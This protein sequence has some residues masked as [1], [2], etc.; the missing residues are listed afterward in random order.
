MSKSSESTASKL[1]E[2]TLT[3]TKESWLKRPSACWVIV[4]LILL[5]VPIVATVALAIYSR[6]AEEWGNPNDVAITNVTGRSVTVSWRTDSKTKGLVI[7]GE[8]KSFL[9]GVFAS[10]SKNVA[11][12]DRDVVNARLA[13][14]ERQMSE[15]E[16]SGNS[17]VDYG[18][19]EENVV[20]DE[21]GEY[22]VHHVTIGDLDPEKKYFFMIGNGLRFLAP[23]VDKEKGG[24]DDNSFMTYAELEDVPMPSPAYGK[25]VRKVSS[26]IIVED[27]EKEG[28]AEFQEIE[29]SLPVSDGVMYMRMESPDGTSSGL[30]SC[31]LAENGSWYIDLS[32]IRMKDGKV[33]LEEVDEEIYYLMEE[34]LQVKTGEWDDITKVITT[35]NDAP[36]DDIVVSVSNEAAN[37]EYTDR[38]LSQNSGVSFVSKVYAISCANYADGSGCRDEGGGCNCDNGWVGHVTCEAARYDCSGEAPAGISGYNDDVNKQWIAF[39]T[40]RGANACWN[41][42]N[43]GCDDGGGCRNICGSP[44][45]WEYCEE[46][47]SEEPPGGGGVPA[48]CVPGSNERGSWGE[49]GV[50]DG[51]VRPCKYHEGY[52]TKDGYTC[53]ADGSW[54]NPGDSCGG[55][56]PPVVPDVCTSGPDCPI[57]NYCRTEATY[58]GIIND[59][60]SYDA[61]LCCRDRGTKNEVACCCDDPSSNCW[62]TGGGTPPGGKYGDCRDSFR[63]WAACD[64][65]GTIFNGFVCYGR[66]WT[67]H[68]WSQRIDDGSTVCTAPADRS[69]VCTIGT[70][71]EISAGETCATIPGAVALPRVSSG[72][73]CCSTRCWCSYTPS[74]DAYQH[75]IVY[76]D[77]CRHFSASWCLMGDPADPDFQGRICYQ[78][79]TTCDCGWLG[80]TCTGPKATQVCSVMDFE[81]MECMYDIGSES[82]GL[83]PKA[84]AAESKIILSSE[85]GLFAFDE[86]GSYCVD[87]DDERYCFDISGPGSHKLYVDVNGDGRYGEG[88]VDLSEDGKEIELTREAHTRTW[89]VN[90]GYNF[91]SFDLVD[92]NTGNMASDWLDRMNDIYDD[93]FYSIGIYESGRWQIIGNRGGESYGQE[94]FQ[95]IPGRGYILSVARDIEIKMEGKKVAGAVPVSFSEGWNLAAIHGSNKLYSA[96]DW[97][98][99]IDRVDNLDADNVTWWNSKD[100][101]FVGLQ[102]EKD[103]SGD[104]QTYGNDF[105]IDPGLAYFVRIVEGSGKWEPD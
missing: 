47:P 97:I 41:G 100:S 63:A 26:E 12:D 82:S 75:E 38:N 11:Y 61:H 16:K 81:K 80:C 27:A 45:S 95:I 51:T 89:E 48:T 60:S 71:D 56:T 85:N 58:P 29:K 86:S 90:E 73:K 14:A 99:D 68:Y 72:E 92:E 35:D 67:G 10:L 3:N 57:T 20:V 88:D 33:F 101:K 19:F 104:E 36:A 7:Y 103:R 93:A 55:V 15:I 5:V 8:S 50:C 78:D 77:W 54:A 1:S 74:W 44:G 53:C 59:C 17:S 64:C 30:V 39:C 32:N 76:G 87:Y 13:A 24:D 66:N 105:P 43:P 102:M 62:G 4:I 37:M 34:H 96:E 9:P 28:E 94:D 79:G 70:K 65:P 40:A 18:D 84:Y 98:V 91:I 52:V 31:S 49:D 69:C 25:V 2:Q 6:Y 21:V 83:V 46:M 22:Y 42:S 23:E